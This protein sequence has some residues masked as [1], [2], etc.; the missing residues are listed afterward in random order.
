MKRQIITDLEWMRM[1]LIEVMTAYVEQQHQYQGI[2]LHAP[3]L[4]SDKSDAYALFLSENDLTDQDRFLLCVS[5]SRYL[6]DFWKMLFL[7][8]N[9]FGIHVENEF[10]YPTFTTVVAILA[11]NDLEKRLEVLEVLKSDAVLFSKQVVDIDQKEPGQDMMA[12]R[13]KVHANWRELFLWNRHELPRYSMEFPAEQLTTDLDWEELILE[14]FPM[15]KLEE[16]SDWMENRDELANVVKGS[17]HLKPGYRCLFYGPSGTGKSLAAALLGKR[18]GIPVFRIDL[19]NL[20]SKYVG[21]TSKN[22]KRIFDLAEDKNWILFFDEG[23]AIFGKRVDTSQTDNKTAS[24]ANQD[25]AFLL[26]RIERFNGL[27]LVA[28][29][30]RKNMDAAFSRRFE[31]I[32]HFNIPTPEKAMEIWGEY[33]PKHIQINN[34]AQIQ[35]LIAENRLSLASLYNV[36]HRLTLMSISKKQNEFKLADI[37]KLMGEEK[38]K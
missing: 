33:L 28:T 30:M 11:G 2:A 1:T 3:K 23:D 25:I 12:C 32:I 13:L 38:M 21:E 19:S 9:P 14:P 7:E 18:F 36:M 35:R 24:Y 4:S 31:N 27:V 37:T 8:K 34:E 6:G 22:L 17:G 5:L 29:N 16:I 10:A 26:Q 15:A 20:V